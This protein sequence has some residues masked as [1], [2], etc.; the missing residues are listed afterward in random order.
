VSVAYL[1]RVNYTDVYGQTKVWD[2]L[3]YNYLHYQNIVIPLKK[4]KTE[5]TSEF[6]GAYV[7]SPECGMYDWIVSFDLTSLY[8]SLIRFCNI[9]PD[10][11]LDGVTFDCSVDRLLTRSI[12]T[13]QVQNMNVCLAANGQCFRKDKHGFLPELM[14]H[15]FDQR[16]ASKK[17]A[18]SFKKKLENKDVIGD[19]RK[20]AEIQAS[21]YDIKQ[22][23]FKIL[24]NSGYGALGC[25][26]WR[27]YDIRQAEAVT[28]TGQLAIRWIQNALNE[29]LNKTLKTAN[30]DYAIG[31]DTD[32]VY[33]NL[34]PLVS[35]V[36]PNITDKTKIV[37]ALNG[38]CEKV[39]QPFIAKKYQELFEYMNGY[40][41]TLDMKREVIAD[42]GI[43]TAKKRYALNVYDS[44]GVRYAKPK[45]K[46]V[47]IE[48][49]RSSTPQICRKTLKKSIEIML[50]QTEA[51]LIKYVQQV[52]D[53]F[54]K[55]PIVDIASPRG[56]NGMKKYANDS[57]LYIKGTP[58]QVKGALIY[59][60]L[61]KKH[62]LTRKY[63]K[64]SDGDKIKFIY[65]KTPNPTPD[66]IL[67][68]PG[69]IPKEF[70]I[71][72]YVD[73]NVQYEKAFLDP[74][75]SIAHAIQWNTEEVNTLE[76]F[77]S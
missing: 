33:L 62:G 26:S 75:H 59:N 27:H 35:K 24:L 48:V 22:M 36:M 30:I 44:E 7:K 19:E 76:S 23:A 55:A 38:F 12:D 57:T 14:S 54:F 53:E 65:L 8:P 42:R 49:Q 3:I 9:S 60:D 45:L 43:W 74:L 77:L 47:G 61:L 71:E 13:R 15:F 18:L 52:R 32:S 72:K 6:S 40:E 41:Q 66:K 68:F 5:L 67:S 11:L 50:T 16:K 70:D 29:F 46:I 34:G 28:I 56:I 39:L 64:I 51:D 69:E 17:K 31:A 1:S 4:Q 2:M 58:S 25:Q 37:D 10:T 21:V 20:D 63:E 73:R